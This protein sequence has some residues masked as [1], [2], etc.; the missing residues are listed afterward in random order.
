MDFNARWYDPAIARFTSI[1]PMADHLDQVDKSPFAFSWN[2]PITLSDP[3]GE[4]P[5]AIPILIAAAAEALLEAAV[6]ATVVVIGAKTVEDAATNGNLSALANNSTIPLSAQLRQD[7]YLTSTQS[8]SRDKSLNST[9]STTTIDW[10]NNTVENTIVESNQNGDVVSSS[11]TKIDP[12]TG[13]K[14]GGSGKA[15]SHTIKHSSRKR[16]KDA[17]RAGGKGTPV[18]HTKDAKGGPHYHHGSGKKGKGKR[19]KGYG[20]KSGKISDNVHHEYPKK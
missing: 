19:T 16:A 10:E 15:R 7:D 20:S 12:K 4:F 13:Q 18:K 14:L 3:S 5:F 2:N 9:T 17:A 1:D 6:V 8:T 11:G